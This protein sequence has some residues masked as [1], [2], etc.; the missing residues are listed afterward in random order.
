MV[1]NVDIP[2]DVADSWYCGNVTI[3]LKEAALEPSSPFR[4]AAE[5]FDLLKQ[6]SKPILFLYSDGGPD[7][8]LTYLSVQISLIALFRSLNLD[9]LCAAR[10]APCQSW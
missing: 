7:H 8:R 10:T 4:H 3:T 9:Y 5:L 2:D 6:E 1:L